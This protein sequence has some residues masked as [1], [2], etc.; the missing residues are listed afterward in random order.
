M[1]YEQGAVL[2]LRHPV[3]RDIFALA[4]PALATLIAE[5]LYV[6]TDTAIV[7]HLGTDQLAGLALA[8]GVLLSAFAICVFLAYGTT[9]AVGRLLGAGRAAEAA[10]QAAQGLWL[11]FGLGVALALVLWPL[12]RPVLGLLGGERAVLDN[13]DIYLSVS[14]AGLPA[15]LISLAGVGYLRG[16]RDTRT[17]LVVAVGTALINLALEVVLI[18]GLDRGIGASALAT[19]F[20]QWLG[21]IV[22]LR[23]IATSVRALGV[24]VRPRPAAM[25]ALVRVGVHLFVRTAALRGSLLVGTATAARL[26]KPELAAYQVGFEIWAFLALALDALAIAAQSLVSHALGAGDSAM[27]RAVGTRVSQLGVLTGALLG[28]AV[29]ALRVPLAHL[30]SGD[31]EV[32]RLTALSLV[33]VAITQPVN[34]WVFALDGVLIGAGDQR[35]LALAMPVAFAVYVPTAVAVGALDASIGWLWGALALFMTARLVAL[36]FRF[37]S[38]RWLVV[39]ASR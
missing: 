11:A 31:P 7:G 28:I 2:A 4:L 6:L 21:A 20:A 13:A 19:V 23:R 3:D 25:A 14:L 37:R 12:S 35:Y 39:G 17:P 18:Y 34:G 33:F 32:V 10:D 26:G 8:S 9:A 30:F 5:P 1:V 16:M 15:L 38:P 29:V 27:A 24:P 36:Q 22:Y